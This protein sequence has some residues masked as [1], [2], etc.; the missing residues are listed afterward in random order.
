MRLSRKYFDL[1]DSCVQAQVADQLDAVSSAH[2]WGALPNLVGYRRRGGDAAR[3]YT[4]S[5][6]LVEVLGRFQHEH[7]VD[8]RS[9]NKGITQHVPTDM[10]AL[11]RHIVLAL[12]HNAQTPV[13]PAMP[14][15]P[16]QEQEHR[17]KEQTLRHIS[18]LAGLEDFAAVVETD[19]TAKGIAASLTPR[20]YTNIQREAKNS[21]A[22]V[23]FGRLMTIVPIKFY[24]LA[25][26]LQ[27]LK[28]RVAYRGDCAKGEY[29]AAAVYQELGALRM[30]PSRGMPPRLLMRLRHTFRRC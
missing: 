16:S 29:G 14:V 25:K 19:P 13:A 21:G 8:E 10:P 9:K 22:K 20:D 1:E 26:H 12:N 17:E 2:L 24:E 23:H 18:P 27:K 11:C 5:T 6:P 7:K 4:S 15:V 28:G 3:F 30:A